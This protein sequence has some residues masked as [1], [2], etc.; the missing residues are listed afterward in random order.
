M[1]ES[2]ELAADNV[3][4]AQATLVE[5]MGLTPEAAAAATWCTSCDPRLDTEG[6]ETVQGLLEEFAGLSD[7]PP[8]EEYVW[9]PA[10]DL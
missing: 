4:D 8:V 2:Q 5:N 3:E 7:L 6:L 1:V 9:E 10:L